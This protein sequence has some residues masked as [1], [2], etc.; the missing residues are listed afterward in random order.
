MVADYHPLAMLLQQD[1]ALNP[2]A[3]K[4]REAILMEA[5]VSFKPQLPYFSLK[6]WIRRSPIHEHNHLPRTSIITMLAWVT[7]YP[8]AWSVSKETPYGN[9]WIMPIVTLGILW[10]IE[11]V[12]R[13]CGNFY[14]VQTDGNIPPIFEC[15]LHADKNR[16]F[17]VLSHYGISTA[18][19]LNRVLLEEKYSEIL[20]KSLQQT[21][22]PD[23][24]ISPL[25]PYLAEIAEQEIIK[26]DRH[27]NKREAV[28]T[29]IRNLAAAFPQ[30]CENLHPVFQNAYAYLE[31]LDD[32]ET[33]LFYSRLMPCYLRQM[34]NRDFDQIQADLYHITSQA[35]LEH[36]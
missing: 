7:L 21:E 13:F 4:I 33:A 28:K 16:D 34:L 8:I 14:S 17:A 25:L 24:L 32:R 10:L 9:A 18:Q 23:N 31:S 26:G 6:K 30:E 12:Y 36:P 29:C 20:W 3:A 19:F 11:N 1:R 35:R 2:Y 5:S 15:L 27:E 22:S